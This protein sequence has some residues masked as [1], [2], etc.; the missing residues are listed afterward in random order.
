[1]V[2]SVAGF[3]SA[4][5]LYM[6]VRRIGVGILILCAV[7]VLIFAGTVLLPGDVAQAILGQSATPE[8]LAA[9]RLELGLDKPAWQRYFAWVSGM[10]QG[11]FGM[12]L[13][14]QVPVRQL[15]GERLGNTL[16]LAGLTTVVAVPL[17]IFLGLSAAMFPLSWWDRAVSIG[18]LMVVSVPEFFLATLFVL[19]FAVTLHWFPA[20]A[21]VVEYGSIA[22]LLWSLALPVITLTAT[23]LAHM[24]RMTRAAVLNIM[25]APFIEMAILKG[26]PLQRLILRHALPNAIGPIVNV[27]ALNLAYLVSGVVVVE[28]IFNYPG[29]ARLTV[30]AV[31]KRDMPLLQGCVVFFCLAYVLLILAADLVS[32]AS[33]PKLRY[34]K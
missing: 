3:I 33:N 12:S 15:I 9:L 23:V 25:S 31:A 34:P 8:N 22:E 30:D 10:L 2:E 20:Q 1:M 24:S 21:R 4:P 5:M 7:S 16:L 29:L 6:V 26:V 27:V 11:D 32:I 18:S 28:T 19:L 13:S 17:S 14:A